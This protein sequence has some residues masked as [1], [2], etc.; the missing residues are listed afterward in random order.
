MSTAP[1]AL[2]QNI[3]LSGY[4]AASQTKDRTGDPIDY[5]G[6]FAYNT[7]RY[8][9][10]VDRTVVGPDFNPE[11]GFLTRLN[12]R[13]TFASARFSPRPKQNRV[14]RRYSYEGSFNYESDNTNRLQSREAQADWRLDRQN[15]D[16]FHVEAFRNFERL[17]KPLA[18]ATGVTVPIGSYGFS[19]VRVAW[20]P[21]Q[22]HAL[23]GTVSFDAGQFYD[24]TK[25][26][27]SMNARYGFSRQL[28]VEPNISLNW[29]ERAGSSAVVKGTGAR[30]TF[31]MTP[32]MVVAALVQYASAT[33]AVST[34][35][36]FRWEYQPGSEL[37]VVY[38]D[39]HDTLAAN[40]T[41]SL[42]SRGVVVKMNRLLRF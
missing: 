41:P 31:T 18:L 22:Q 40:G 21:G 10:Q 4:I 29:V 36:R 13:R 1:F 9:L 11:V 42:Q 33:N 23:S 20:A 35:L 16:V 2:F 26:T 27:V 30:T 12:F 5:R 14:I 34:N 17:T 8:G 38:T 39:G 25:R 32:R 37:F 24:G 19:H 6:N 15:I 28:G 7:D 3:N